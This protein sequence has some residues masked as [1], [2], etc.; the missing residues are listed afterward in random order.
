MRVGWIGALSL[1]ALLVAAACDDAGDVTGSPGP[2]V[3]E[4][5]EVVES[6]T[7]NG[8]V[9]TYRPGTPPA[10]RSGPEIALTAHG[11]FITGGSSR[12]EIESDD[13]LGGF[14]LWI[15]GLPGWWEVTL[16]AGSR[17]PA[18]APVIRIS[19]RA[20]PGTFTLSVAGND[21][22]EFGENLDRDFTL[23]GTGTGELQINVTWDLA[24]DVDLHVIEPSGEEIFFGNAVSDTD[25][26]LDLDSNRN[27][28][29]DDV[30]A[31]NVTWEPGTAASG[32]YV[33]RVNLWDSCGQ[34][35]ADEVGNPDGNITATVTVMIDGTELPG[36]PFSVVLSGPG[37][38]GGLG[39]GVD[40]VQFTF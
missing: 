33:V 23:L 16:P 30:F 36:G 8:A 35:G 32:N 9:A 15:D 39:A 2:E 40:V 28:D 11:T 1:G 38:N 12:L 7:L 24:A 37:N 22:V 34:N 20:P 10:G 19:Q 6:V 5:F 27:C 18:L 21:G 25:G 31:E 26:T 4:A 29:I 3:T 13:A 17:E 14:A